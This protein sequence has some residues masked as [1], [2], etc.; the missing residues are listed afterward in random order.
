MRFFDVTTDGTRK[1][2]IAFYWHQ[3]LS[4]LIQNTNNSTF[5][6]CTLGHAEKNGI[7]GVLNLRHLKFDA[8][9]VFSFLITS[10]FNHNI[11][12]PFLETLEKIVDSP[13]QE[14][15]RICLF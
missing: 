1:K 3:I 5:F 12:H 2:L 10:K 9:T 11:L 4:F 14:Q 13:E 6:T 8:S 15:M 7:I